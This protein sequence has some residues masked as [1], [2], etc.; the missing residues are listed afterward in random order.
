[1]IQI[2]AKKLTNGRK[3]AL[4]PPIADIISPKVKYV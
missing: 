1:M 4:I 2:G 3:N